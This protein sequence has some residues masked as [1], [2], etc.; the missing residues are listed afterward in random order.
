MGTEPYKII[1]ADSHVIEPW[2]L[3]QERLPKQFR[4]RAPRLVRVEQTDKLVCEDVEMPP[5]GVAAGVFRRNSEVRQTGRWDDDIPP[6]AYN[7]DAR[8]AEIDRDGIWGEVM[9]P[10]FGLGFYGINDV[11]FKWALLQAYND[12]L[13]EFCKSHPARF[14][15]IAMIAN[16]DVELAA[17]ELRRAHKLGLAGIMIPTVA[18]EGVPQYHE[19][20][21]DPLWQAAVECKMPVNVHAATTRDRNKKSNVLQVSGRN[22]VK[23]PLKYELVA[24]PMLSMVFGGVFERFPELT[25]VSAENE[26]GWAPHLLE[27]ADY[28][29]ERYAAVKVVGFEGRIPRKP[30]EYWRKNMRLTF[31]RDFVAIRTYDMVG[32]ETLMFQT[33]FPHGVSTY[34]NSRKMCEK[35]FAGIDETVR[36]K[37]VYQNAADV[38][39]F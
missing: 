31:L 19:R 14:K 27:R 6:S 7:P 4:D 21:M 39:G 1:S 20:G 35:L 26:A 30:S 8:I 2:F 22:P 24:L 28:E 12:W 15:G 34:P 13:A 10:T 23:S 37:I 17:A 38:Y 16:D 9:Y 5:I 3:W 29:W 18:G 36:H 33:D 32:A 11:G 25:F